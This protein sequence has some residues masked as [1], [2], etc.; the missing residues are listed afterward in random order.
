MIDEV[1]LGDS[2]TRRFRNELLV[3][4]VC[5][6]LFDQG[7]AVVAGLLAATYG[8]FIHAECMLMKSFLSPLFTM[9]A[10]YATLKFG[11]TNGAVDRRCGYHSWLG[12]PRDREPHSAAHSH[13]RHT[14][15]QQFGRCKRPSNEG[16]VWS[17]ADSAVD[18]GGK[19]RG[20]D[21]S[22]DAPHYAV[23]GELVAVT[24]GG[25]RSLLH[26]VGTLGDRQLR[27]P[28]P[29]VREQSVPRT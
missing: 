8:P 23:S 20:D 10:L 11:E 17:P 14:L 22:G 19:L 18:S 6:C 3:Y 5:V 21:S 26:G 24:A 12:M 15:V 1:I 16:L 4:P 9:L 25:W 7:T 2:I 29:F 13:R 27:E 28:P